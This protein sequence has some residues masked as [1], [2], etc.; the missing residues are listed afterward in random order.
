MG[1]LSN[2]GPFNGVSLAGLCWPANSGLF[3]RYCSIPIKSSA[4]NATKV[5]KK[6]KIRNRYNQVPHLNG[7]NIWVSEKNT[8]KHHTQE[9]QEV[10]PFPAGDHMAARNR[11]DNIIKT[12]VKH[13]KRK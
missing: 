13:I 5:K 1:F 11:R 12:N 6:T 2:T 10:S 8:R 4:V 9:S 7:R 3:I